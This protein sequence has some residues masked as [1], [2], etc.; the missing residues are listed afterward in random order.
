MLYEVITLHFTFIR[1]GLADTAC[2]VVLVLAIAS[3]PY[4]LRS[5]YNFV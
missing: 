5:S 2:G 1:L 3:Y 4:M